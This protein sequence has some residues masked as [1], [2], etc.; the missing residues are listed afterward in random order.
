MENLSLL[1]QEAL[2]ILKKIEY[3]C[4]S[5]KATDYEQVKEIKCFEV[6]Y[7]VENRSIV[8]KLVSRHNIE[9]YLKK[10][11]I[12][13]RLHYDFEEDSTGELIQEGMIE[14]GSV[15]EITAKVKGLIHKLV[16]KT[17]DET[18]TIH[19]N[20]KIGV[21]TFNGKKIK[22]FEGIQRVVSTSLVIAGC[23]TKVSWDE[24]NEKNLGAG[25]AISGD[26]GTNERT[27]IKKRIN[28]AVSEINK[29]TEKYLKDELLIGLKDN[30]YWLQHDVTIDG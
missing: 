27:L 15:E 1:E 22:P 29:K 11:G 20:T 7:A 9:N 23:D 25:E 14:G 30:E 12:D 10:E 5:A 26:P 28:G 13:I 2:G 24:I 4:D 3:C 16:S 8:K 17:K 18:I 6:H 21:F 19:Y